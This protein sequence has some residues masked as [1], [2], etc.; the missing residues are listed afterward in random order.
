[1]GAAPT[2]REAISPFL[3]IISVGIDMMPYFAAVFAKLYPG[4]AVRCAIIWT[5]TP[6]IVELSG[7]ALDHALAQVKAA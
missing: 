4:R 2:W 5:E 1:M 6:E 3:N 7:E